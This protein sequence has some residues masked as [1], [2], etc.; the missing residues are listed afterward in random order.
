M[1][2]CSVSFKLSFFA[3]VSAVTILISSTSVHAY[4]FNGWN[5]DGYIKS[6]FGV[7]TKEKPFNNSEYGSS[8]D[9]IATARQ[10]MRWNLNGQ[11]SPN[12]GIRAEVL[13]AWEPEYP[14]EK[15]VEDIDA[16]YYSSFD[17]R[18]LTIE[19][20]PT[21]SHTLRFGRQIINW[22]EAISGR[23]VDQTNPEDKRYLLGFTSLE[24]TY[25]PLWM[26]RGIHDFSNYNTTV[27]WLIAP[28]W[29]ADRFEHK[30]SESA[31]GNRHGDGS[32]GEPWARFAAN[33]ESRVYKYNGASMVIKGT[34]GSAGSIYGPPFATGY[35]GSDLLDSW[36]EGDPIV[37]L[38][39]EQASTLGLRGAIPTT[40]MDE[41]ANILWT[42]FPS[43]DG[44][45][46]PRYNKKWTD[47]NF[48]NTRWGFKNKHMLWSAEFGYSFYQG[49]A[50]GGMYHYRYRDSL[51]RAYA[52]L[53]YE[54]IVPRDDTY[55]LFGTY[56]TPYGIISFEGAYKPDRGFYK[57]LFGI[58]F[59]SPSSPG[60][61]QRLAAAHQARLGNVVEK[62]LIHTLLGITREQNIP[63]LNKY[64]V[65][66]IRSQ[67]QA[68][69]YLENMDDVVETTTYFT[70]PPQVNNEFLISIG[71]SYAYRKYSPG[72]TLVLNPRGQVYSSMK[73]KWV[74]EGFNENL[75][76]EIGWTNIW[77]AN[78]Y[79]TSTVLARQNSLVVLELKYEFN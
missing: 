6:Q 7:F 73:F 21:Y 52:Y 78:D 58:P 59:G 68:Y 10:Q 41:N 54:Y 22:G 26:F 60:F 45:R 34:D 64:N 37:P 9:N 20:K 46:D 72:L 5:I 16:N 39:R 62:D 51:S 32:T 40:L 74:P 17:W 53:I 4:Y 71:T 24:E 35:H 65:F 15:N 57:N 56:Q 33:P 3:L 28:I 25:M 36:N 19:Y 70:T 2:Y 69:W 23:V 18:E 29:Q 55:G 27:E 79:S 67:W 49:P 14:G 66:T 11:L 77:G 44:S 63:L 76:V 42:E 13:G 8:D 47:H 12:I 38:T 31:S 1:N 43:T 75:D 61:E 50:D 30:R 48:K